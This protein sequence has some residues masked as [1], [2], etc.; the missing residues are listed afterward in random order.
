LLFCWEKA[1]EWEFTSYITTGDNNTS[2]N[3]IK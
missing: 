3:I 2:K 1:N